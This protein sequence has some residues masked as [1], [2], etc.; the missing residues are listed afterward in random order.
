MLC[1]TGTDPYVKLLL[2]LFPEIKEQKSNMC[3]K[4]SPKM[5]YNYTTYS[6]L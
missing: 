4:F 3:H 2:Q 6:H 5:S 1:I